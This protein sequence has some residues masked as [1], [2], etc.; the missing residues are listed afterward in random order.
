MCFEAVEL[1][2]GSV[3]LQLKALFNHCRHPDDGENHSAKWRETSAH[4]YFKT[5]RSINHKTWRILIVSSHETIKHSDKPVVLT[6]NQGK[7]TK[8]YL[9]R[10]E[11]HYNNE[12]EQQKHL[13]NC[14]ERPCDS[15]LM[16]KV[17]QRNH[18]RGRPTSRSCHIIWHQHADAIQ[19]GLSATN[20]CFS[21]GQW[22]EISQ[23][24]SWER[25]ATAFNINRLKPAEMVWDELDCRVMES[26]QQVFS[27]YENS[28]RT[29]EKTL[30]VREST[31]R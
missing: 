11:V 2:R 16:A 30:Q 28:L 7:K 13:M 23:R 18:E 9:S 5:W 3:G 20:S 14:S 1:G 31:R 26:S 21:T 15:D 24:A 6:T 4:H 12:F 22:P 19:S 27:T 29:V 10:R 8:C 25:A 17:L